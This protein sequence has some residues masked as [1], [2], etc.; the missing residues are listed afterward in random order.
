MPTRI[1]SDTVDQGIIYDTYTE[2]ERQNKIME[3]KDSK[4]K[5]K[6]VKHQKIDKVQEL[7]NRFVQAA[8]VLERMINQN[9][10]MD[11]AQGTKRK[12]N[13]ADICP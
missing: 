3:E 9:T 10:Y 13:C 4:S 7:S 2:L 8:R 1:F 11:I 5:R 6:E 12:L